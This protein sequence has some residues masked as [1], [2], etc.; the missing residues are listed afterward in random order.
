M[1][2]VYILYSE[3]LDRFYTGSCLEFEFRFEE[4]LQKVYPHSFTSNSNDWRL[5]F[6]VENL[7]YEQARAIEAHIKKMKSTTYVRNLVKYPDIIKRLRERY[8]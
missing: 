2:A 4:H 6:L 3:R 8:A 1:A 7:S 5:F